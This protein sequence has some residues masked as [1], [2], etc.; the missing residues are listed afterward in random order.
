MS[1]SEHLKAIGVSRRY[2]LRD[3]PCEICGGTRFALLQSKGRIGEPGVYGDLPIQ[4]CRRCG[5]VMINPRYE[6]RFYQDYY[7]N[8]Y[9]R[10]ATGTVKPTKRYINGQIERGGKVLKFLKRW[11]G[12]PGRMLDLGCASGATMIP[13][14]EAGW[15]IT[16]LDPDA[17]AVAY[18]KRELK[19][20]VRLGEAEQLPFKDA[21]FDLVVCLGPLEHAY[22][23]QKAM[24]EC[25]RVLKPGG[26]LLNRYR[27]N[28]LWG[29]PLEY[30]NHN[31]YRYFSMTTLRLAMLGHGF[32][33]EERS[34]KPV[35]GKPGV[36]YL[37]ARRAGRSGGR[38][39]VLRAILGGVRDEVEV[40]LRSLEA[41]DH[42][43]H[44]RAERFL[45]LV[46][47]L[48]GD[49]GAVVRAVDNREVEYRLLPGLVSEAVERGVSEARLFLSEAQAIRPER[50][51]AEQPCAV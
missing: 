6:R 48:Q 45:A 2:R 29:S 11:V 38:Q 13:F 35:E 20:P 27:S 46:E 22:D 28:T 9:R 39:E 8:A 18:A 30:F 5:F 51:C 26:L 25:R 4:G 33:S 21:M 16:G 1:A 24:K 17:G 15:H 34:D 42:A 7:R 12:R 31:H 43:F 3:V 41:Y 50:I 37:V 49:A 10:V 19:L 40:I 47:R 23:F 36:S 32:V 44:E 14:R